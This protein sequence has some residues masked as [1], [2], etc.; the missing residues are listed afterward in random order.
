MEKSMKNIVEHTISA[1]FKK[2]YTG[3][4]DLTDKESFGETN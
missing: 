1:Q 2:L 4:G 3:N